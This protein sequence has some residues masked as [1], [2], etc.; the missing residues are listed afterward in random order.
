MTTRN[1]NTARP[2]TGRPYRTTAFMV[3][4][5]YL[6]G[7][8]VGLSGQGLFQSVLGAPNYLATVPSHSM[9]LAVGAIL[10]LLAV[11]G[12]VAHG[13]LMFPLLKQ[14]SE[15]VAIGYLGARIVDATFIAVMVI[16]ILIQIPLGNEYLRAAAPDR[17]HL[18]S[19]STVFVYASQS[20]YQIGMSALGVSGVAL[21]YVLYQAGSFHGRW[22]SGASSA[23]QS[24][25]SGCS[26]KW[27]VWAR[28]RVLD[29]WRALGGVHRGVAHRA[30]LLRLKRSRRSSACTRDGL[31]PLST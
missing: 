23:T 24:S 10:W 25:W 17:L 31:V 11:A 2:W 27:R 6:A 1:I 16:F 3:G 29:S 19:L 22:P 7:F 20:A 28:A 5:V 14:H 18:Q 13:V 21:C 4:V 26:R 9:M 8:V 15:R 12:D 30:G